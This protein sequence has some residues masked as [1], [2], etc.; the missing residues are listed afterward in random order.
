MNRKDNENS[1]R[2]PP[3]GF[4]LIELLVVIAIIAILAAMLLPALAA[5][6]RK[7]QLATCQNNFHE[8]YIACAVY[9]GDY[10]DYY[11]IC[12]V[13]GGN[14][15]GKFDNLSFVDYTEYFYAG[16]IT[17]P[18]TP[19]PGPGISEPAGTYDCLGYLYET[20]LVGNGKVCFCPSFPATSQHSAAY[21][22]TPVFPSA[23]IPFS[24]GNYVIQD[25]TLYNPRL[26]D[27]TN[28]VTA[29][30]F[31]KSSSVWSGTGSGGLH[32]FATDFL[33]SGDGNTSS[34]SQSTFAHFPSKGFDVLFV[35]GSVKFVA[36]APAF[37][38]VSSGQLP[39]VETA[40]S[41][42]AYNQLFNLLEQ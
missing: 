29:R 32:L 25:S 11:P 33:A 6:Q 21:Y 9:A 2:I 19:I 24:S 40:A 17:T 27:A 39:T 26:K 18:N 23:G 20:K 22:S 7:A 8:V 30:G 16:S 1:N 34:Y 13:G 37:A 35:D 4:T 5:A 38:M 28:G 41:N 42:D 3:G 31:P 15:G 14:S 10:N 12:T 36:S